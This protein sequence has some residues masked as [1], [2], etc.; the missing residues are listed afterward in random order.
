MAAEMKDMEIAHMGAEK[1]QPNFGFWQLCP[2][3]NGEG[4]ISGTHYN[5]ETLS[6]D[7]TCPVC[8]GEKKLARPVIDN[9]E[10]QQ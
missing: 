4:Y 7:R 6:V 5:G 8:N 9:N 10:K 3:C 2:K 1:P